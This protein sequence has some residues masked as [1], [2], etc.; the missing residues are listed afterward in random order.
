MKRNSVFRLISLIAFF[1]CFINFS[2]TQQQVNHHANFNTTHQNMWGPSYNSFSIDKEIT[3]FEKSWNVPFG[4]GNSMITSI[5]GQQFGAAFDGEFSGVIGSKVSLNGFTNGEVDVLYPVNITL[6]MPTDLTYD[7]GD[8]VTVTSNY[9]VDPSAELVSRF[10][11]AGDV[12]WDLYFQMAANLNAKL[13]AFGCVNFPIIPSFNTGMVDFNIVT[14]NASGLWSLGPA[15]PTDVVQGFI[16]PSSFYP[17]KGIFPFSVSPKV[18]GTFSSTNTVL[19]QC[20]NP[21]GAPYIIPNY[22]SGIYGKVTIPFVNTVS[23]LGGKNISASGDSTYVSMNLEIFKLL[24]SVLGNYPAGPIKIIGQGLSN[25]SGQ[26][27]FGPAYV[28][29]NFFSA[30]FN[31]KSTNKQYF[32]FTP[33]VYGTFQFPVPVDYQIVDPLANTTSDWSTSSII[34]LKIGQNINYKFPCYFEKVDITPTYNIIGKIKNH[35]YDSISFDFNMSAFKFAFTIPRIDITPAYTVDEICLNIP[36][37]C[38]TWSDIFRICTTRQCTPSFTIP[39]V[40]FS[41][42]NESYGPLWSHSIP[43]GA[44]KYDWFNQTWDLEGFVPITFPSF[45]MNAR[46]ISANATST[47]VSCYDFNDGSVTLN[48]INT[49]SP[50]TFLWTNGATTQNL[51]GINDGPYEVAILDA[52]GCQLLTGATV[53][54]PQAA[55]SLTYKSTDKLCAGGLANGAINVTTTGGTAPYT[56]SWSNLAT[57]EDLTGLDVGTYSL[58][59]TDSKGCTSSISVTIQQ[60]SILGQ[61]AAISDI[62]CKGGNSGAIAVDVYGGVLPYVYSWNSGQIIE[63]ITNLTAGSY[64]LTISDGNGCVSSQTYPVVEPLLP[65]NLTSTLTDINC[66]GDKTGLID[67]TTTGGTS[68]YTYTWTNN[69]GIILPFTTEDLTNISASTYTV[70]VTDANGCRASLSQTLTQPSAPISSTST[71]T[72]VNCYGANTGFIN[73]GIAGG[74]APYSYLW[75]NA[76]TAATVSNL[77]AGTYTL[78]VTD[79]KGCLATYSYEIMQPNQALSVTLL[80]THILCYGNTTGAIS[81]QVIGGTQG[82]TYLWNNGSTSSSLS[83]LVAGNYS[84][85]I[86]DAK[87]C[88]FNSS[89]L[90]NQPSVPLTNSTIVTQVDCHGNNT[91]AIDLTVNGGTLPYSY[92]W[93]NAQ[94]IVLLTTDQDLSTQFANSYTVKITDGNGCVSYNTSTINEPSAILTFTGTVDDVNCYGLNDG[95]INVSPTGGTTPYSYSWS[96][97]QTTQ[98]LTSVLSGD[99]TL[100]LTDNNNC[101]Y[102]SHFSIVQ[103]NAALSIST[104]VTDA[105]CNGGSTGAIQSHVEG[106][107]SPYT[108]A[109]SNGLTSSL[110]EN[111][112]SGAYSLTVT[113]NQGCT[114]FSGAV[115]GEPAQPLTISPTITQPTCFGYSDGQV[116]LAINGGTQPYHFNWGT[117][118]NILLNNPSETIKGVA[119]NDYLCRV[120]D[121]NGCMV[122]QIV[123][124]GQPSGLVVTAAITDLNCYNDTT[125][126]IDLTI[127]GATPTYTVNWGNGQTTEDL[128]NISANEYA[129]VVSDS[130]GCI[131]RSKANVNQPDSLKINSSITPISC[132]D[133]KDAS[134]VVSTFGGTSPYTFNWSNGQITSDATNLAPGNYTLTITDNHLCLSTFDFVIDLNEE[135]CVDI[136][137]TITPNGDNYNDTW[138]IKNI[139]LYPYATVK[140]FN[141]WGNLV[142]DADKPYKEW[143]GTTKGEPLPSEVYYYI[144]ELNNSMENKYNGTITIIR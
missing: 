81:T 105:L 39:A 103:P 91:G 18:S 51:T 52:N 24:G 69:A 78:N 68:G 139:D 116:L 73:P 15:K 8:V 108:Y 71:I 32:D 101:I 137:N 123:S 143:D 4:T 132:I 14:A 79:S 85:T 134:I 28:S 95:A 83:N 7:Q 126:A 9:T 138:H 6:D 17:G 45:Q 97:G 55:L 128:V 3:I 21:P 93:S 92:S 115:V 2:H 131:I 102:T 98:D 87:G 80:P 90:L 94:S 36:Y 53:L 23:V 65:L 144:I 67:I 19:W 140:V 62:K 64:S 13:C 1:L 125:G 12:K 29:W 59:A 135:S 96:S 22:G 56:Y 82:Y 133:Q 117:D 50:E 104:I 44:V 60:P 33:K 61:T 121:A 76:T 122:Q 119:A 48:L 63:D 31:V 27:T 84:V 30:L 74:T 5:V 58:T 86:T 130:H 70:T 25:L 114:S 49:E 136:P 46:R 72:N 129:Y 112:T 57:T 109:W 141:R 113:D 38:P 40:Y 100:T 10:P 20:Y 35:T 110:I 106:G 42:L 37:P 88:V 124:V 16:N 54:Q 75:S 127:S 142:F 77:I 26:R 47:D 11:K 118:N 107:T 89:V 66:N 99:Y 34:N 41:A 120:F 43:L 111:L